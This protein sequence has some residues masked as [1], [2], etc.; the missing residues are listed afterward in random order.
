MVIPMIILLIIIGIVI[1]FCFDPSEAAWMPP[2]L[3]KKLTGFSCPGCGFQR[4][5][6]AA[7]HGDIISALRYNMLLVF[8]LPWLM[9]VTWGYFDRLP[10]VHVVRRIAH[11]RTIA[12]S[13]VVL[14]FLWWIL[15]NIFGL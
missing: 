5:L 15:R 6:H 13:Y 7:L 8:A 3:F 10:Y 4:A 11:S 1:Y 12:L 14:F 9:A 2:C